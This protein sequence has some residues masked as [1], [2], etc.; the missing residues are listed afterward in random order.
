MRIIRIGNEVYVEI[1]TT[2]AALLTFAKMAGLVVLGAASFYS[3]WVL[4]EF[5]K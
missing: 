3:L 4:L 5:L 2:R 1:T